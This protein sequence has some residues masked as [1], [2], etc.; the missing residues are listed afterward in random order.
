MDDDVIRRK[1]YVR[2]IRASLDEEDDETKEIDFDEKEPEV[3]PFLFAKL[4][5]FCALLLFCGFL[6]C[7]YNSYEIFEKSSTEIIDMI[8]DN[9]YYTFL[10]NY[11]KL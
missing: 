9:Q 10:Q 5:F 1:Q 11:V 8:R 6:F 7:K 4:R 2:Q 3:P